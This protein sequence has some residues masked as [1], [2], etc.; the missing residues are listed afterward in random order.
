MFSKTESPAAID[1]ATIDYYVAKGRR[2]RSVAFV[3]FIKS[4]F[5][6]AEPSPAKAKGVA[7]AA[8]A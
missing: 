6:K 1:Y 2:E 7:Y 8:Q 4:L 5:T 3:A